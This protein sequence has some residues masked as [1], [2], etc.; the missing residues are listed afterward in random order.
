M[1]DININYITLLFNRNHSTEHSEESI[2][3]ILLKSL[4]RE[5]YIFF[6][7]SDTFKGTQ[8]MF[9]ESKFND[10]IENILKSSLLEYSLTEED[11][12]FNTSI[13]NE[14]KNLM[15]KMNEVP[16][17]D[18]EPSYK[19]AL[20]QRK[21]PLK[22]REIKQIIK[23]VKITKKPN[24]TQENNEN[25]MDFFSAL[26]KNIRFNKNFTQ[27]EENTTISSARKTSRVIILEQMD[28]SDIAK[29]KNRRKIKPKRKGAFI[30]GLYKS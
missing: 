28:K 23:D 7:N 4:N 17:M 1:E 6:D 3:D 14:V 21:K 24:L 5:Y 10:V 26:S 25:I 29:I 30:G 9:F 8:Q 20:M 2:K 19:T 12:E 18:E 22:R 16:Y 13:K 15:S 11:I 27:V